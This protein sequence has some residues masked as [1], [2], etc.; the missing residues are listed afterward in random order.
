MDNK[1]TP[2]PTP[3]HSDET[4][5]A[6][7]SGTQSLRR[8]IQILRVLARLGEPDGLRFSDIARETGIP[9]PTVHRILKAMELEG[10]VARNPETRSF[11]LGP[12]AFEIGMAATPQFDLIGMTRPSLTR[13]ADQSGDTSFLF[14]RRG[15]DAV[16]I[17]RVLGHYHIQTPYITV[18]SRQPLGISAGGLAI[19]M[20]Q[21]SEM[22]GKI[23][24]S[25][26][27]RLSHYSNSDVMDIENALQRSHQLGYAFIG[28]R[29]VP[30]VSAIGL[31]IR[32]RSGIPIA[33]IAIASI[34]ERMTPE[35]QKTLS[36]LL[37]RETREIAALLDVND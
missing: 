35:R 15:N 8:L 18:G 2:H 23:L 27:S 6:P 26:G 5:S 3:D 32:T 16:C 1:P 14:I 17:N 28:E 25:I 10:I 20:A 33:A 21:P 24:A 9:A 11:Q 37:R 4:R 22:V 34:S 13:L 12:T 19:L 36:A 30:G 7:V 31:P 29:A